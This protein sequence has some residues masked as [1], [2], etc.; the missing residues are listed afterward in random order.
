MEPPEVTYSVEWLTKLAKTVTLILLLARFIRDRRSFSDCAISYF[1]MLSL[2][3]LT[4]GTMLYLVYRSPSRF[5]IGYF[6]FLLVTF[7]RG[8]RHNGA[9]LWNRLGGGRTAAAI[10]RFL[11]AELH[12][13]YISEIQALAANGQRFVFAVHPH[14]VFAT[15]TLIHFALSRL[16]T[17]MRFGPDIDFRV[18]TINLNFFIP[19]LREW[20][21]ARGFVSA[22]PTTFTELASRGISPVIVPGG[23]EE[24]LHAYPGSADLIFNKRK[25][26]VREALRTGAWLVP[27]Y[28]FGDTE[29]VPVFRNGSI[30]KIQRWIQK[31]LTFATPLALPFFTRSHKLNMVVGAPVPPPLVCS[32]SL[33]ERTALYQATYMEALKSLFHEYFVRFGTSKEINGKGI[34][35]VK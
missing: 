6:L 29:S 23:S 18:M 34:R 15:S 20:L 33:E 26:F 32:G 12:T 24:A 16:M 31:T 25:G 19:L 35:F 17:K 4:V 1:S 9:G 22:D 11:R 7:K 5:A 13:P 8:A 21:L 3:P 28:A 30:A 2:W 14:A 10:K 27:I